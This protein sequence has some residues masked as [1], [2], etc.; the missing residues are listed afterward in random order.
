MDIDAYIEQQKTRGAL[1]SSGTF[2]VDPFKAR[3]KMSQFQTGD[4]AFYLL[5]WVQCGVLAGSWRISLHLGKRHLRFFAAGADLEK[6]P[7]EGIENN[8]G[9]LLA[10]NSLDPLDYLMNGLNILLADPPES[11]EVRWLRGAEPIEVLTIAA[12]GIK[13]SEE[14][15][16]GRHFGFALTIQRRSDPQQIA[17]ETQALHHRCG[18]SPIPVR[19]D[20][21]LVS[22]P[23]NPNSSLYQG[24]FPSRWNGYLPDEFILGE[25]YLPDTGSDGPQ[26]G[27]AVIA[28]KTRSAQLLHHGDLKLQGKSKENLF[29]H[30]CPEEIEP[31]QSTARGL[32]KI[33][34]SLEQ[35]STVTF[36]QFGVDISTRV[37]DG[38]GLQAWICVD[39]FATDVSGC[40]LVE[41]ERYQAMFTHLTRQM[42]HLRKQVLA[43]IAEL[44]ARF[45]WTPERKSAAA[46]T[47]FFVSIYAF[48]GVT[49]WVVPVIG[50][51]WG[52]GLAGFSGIVSHQL[53]KA[54]ENL[55]Q[56]LRWQVQDRLRQ[57]DLAAP[58]EP[59]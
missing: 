29:L 34:I 58:P 44:Q 14:E 18:S 37:L 43:N 7:R 53:L 49:L 10:R 13:R 19:V 56:E 51:I 17:A 59:E 3:Q 42:D 32:I 8:F 1:D 16:D 26:T 11:I 50:K 33:P 2:S 9:R 20:G 57:P 6:L 21:T 54:K 30:L 48:S 15:S 4:P 23:S 36:V 52:T 25:S 55:N 40:Q 38:N 27:V 39:G 46:V 31:E 28:R 22:S 35:A 45:D 47:A 12:S 41:D 24:P 5:R